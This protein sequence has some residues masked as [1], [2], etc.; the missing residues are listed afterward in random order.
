[1]LYTQP[2]AP[3]RVN[4]QITDTF[5]KY[6][7]TRHGCPLS[8]LLFAIAIEPLA[9]FLQNP[10]VKGCMSYTLELKTSLHADDMLFYLVDSANSLSTALQFISCFGDFS[11]FKSQLD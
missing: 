2:T 8:P 1:M 3:L 11:G 10:D 6:H 5:P 7:G 4:N 9:A